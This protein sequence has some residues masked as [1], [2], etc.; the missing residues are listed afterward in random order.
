MITEHGQNKHVLSSPMA[1]VHLF[2]LCSISSQHDIPSC[3]ISNLLLNFE[4][5]YKGFTFISGLIQDCKC[6]SELFR[7]AIKLVLCCKSM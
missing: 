3:L 5:F 2:P 7:T 4:G 6:I 1:L